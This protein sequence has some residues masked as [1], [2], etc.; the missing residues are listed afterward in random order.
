M[1]DKKWYASRT[2][3]V[4]ALAVVGAIVQ[5]VSGQEFLGADD[6]VAILGLINLI[7]RMVTSSKISS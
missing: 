2:L 6:Q 3:W 5:G 1:E 4:N 7:L